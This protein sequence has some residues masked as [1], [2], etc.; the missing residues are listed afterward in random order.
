[1]KLRSEDIKQT[2]VLLAIGALIHDLGKVMLRSMDER[3]KKELFPQL[4]KKEEYR[5][6]FYYAHAYCLWEFI[7]KYSDKLELKTNPL[8]EPI[9]L[10]SSFHHKPEGVERFE[11]LKK[12]QLFGYIYQK[13]DRLSS[14]ERSKKERKIEAPFLRSI[15][16]DIKFQEET[17]SQDIKEEEK[18]FL[19][20]LKPL[21]I[22][23][24]VIFPKS[25]EK[26][27]P[28]SNEFEN[29]VKQYKEHWDKF[30]IEFK[31]VLKNFVSY[32][33]LLFHLYHL[34]YRYFWCV[35]AS[36][37]DP[38]REERH[39]PDI[40]LF[41]HLRTSSALATSFYT[42]YNLE[43]LKN[44]KENELKLIFIRG[45]LTGIQKYLYHLMNIKGVT[46]R[47]RG[48]SFF[49]GM[50]PEVVARALLNKFNY[51]FTNII[52]SGGGNFE[53]VI[54]YEEDISEKLKEFNEEIENT[55][56]KK[57]G[58]VLGLTLG[59][60]KTSYSEFKD[61]GYKAISE[62]LE[63]SLSIKKKTKFCYLLDKN[64]LNNLV[65]LLNP[66]LEDLSGKTFVR[67]RSCHQSF[68]EEEK[69][70]LCEVCETFEK[71]GKELIEAKYLVFSYKELPLPGMFLENI[72]GIYLVRDLKEVY[73]D[74]KE[75]EV[76]CF[77]DTNFV[78]S[79][80]DGFKFVA[81]V[82]PIEKKEDIEEEDVMPFEKLVE[83]AQGDK[84]LAFA[85]ADVD[86]LGLIFMMGLGE[87]Y[88][89]SRVATLSRSLDLFFSGY[90]NKLF[91]QKDSNDEKNDF[92]NKIYTVY[93]GG[94]D[95]FIVGPWD[96]I[97][98]V[99]EAINGKF[100][101]YTC[102]NESFN[103]S[104]GIFI[105][106]D[107]Y[108]LRF[109]AERAKETEDKAKD[110]KPAISALEETLKWDEFKEAL[111]KG[112]EIAKILKERNI[113]RSLFYKFYLLIRN[114][115]EWEKR[116]EEEKRNYPEKYKFYPLFYYYLYRNIKD[117][118]LQSKI[119]DFLLDIRDDYKVRKDALFRAKYVIMKTRT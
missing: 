94:D 4:G 31:E 119:K 40:S 96:V 84:K 1:M 8:D 52:F 38:E 62:K 102:E 20:M 79:K 89:L 98:Y 76:Y 99:M 51:P 114:Y 82:V 91:T 88:S 39:Y 90:L 72:G 87:D 41:D 109:A 67:C 23:E 26:K 107:S 2:R 7:R 80:A 55:L 118:G 104:C 75:F 66:E 24:E 33:K 47:L 59:W 13:A 15:F 112:D 77:N 86:N 65:K 106:R 17:K 58:G 14:S 48:K 45:D 6:T 34:F 57:F 115:K 30:L 5:E 36:T 37:F 16:Q 43:K 42:E 116:E 11:E 29:P 44:E 68:A 110:K 61:H 32:E 60:T 9:I 22:D 113:G 83:H 71:I 97:F 50:L 12:Y 111:I 73:R 93:A 56:F 95:L 3:E 81:N 19:Y 105:G 49:L 64:D 63:R 70:G 21:S 108:P 92:Y 27:K 54:G 78:S 103:I 25:V 74:R 69:G 46:K 101:R 85:R 53:V 35:P 28:L 10:A 100:K 117:E 18:E